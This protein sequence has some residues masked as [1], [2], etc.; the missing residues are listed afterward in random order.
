MQ[1]NIMLSLFENEIS[2]FAIKPVSRCNVTIDTR[3]NSKLQG[4][5]TILTNFCALLSRQFASIFHFYKFAGRLFI[6][7]SN[8]TPRNSHILHDSDKC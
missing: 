3:L 8:F 1:L 6:E 7:P 5:A 4:N 2:A